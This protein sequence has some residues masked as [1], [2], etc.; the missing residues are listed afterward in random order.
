MWHPATRRSPHLSLPNMRSSICETW[1]A[2][3][4][5]PHQNGMMKH[6]L[7]QSGTR[8]YAC[9]VSCAAHVDPVS[10]SL[11]SPFLS[12]FTPLV[13]EDG[14]NRCT[15][16]WWLRYI[17]RAEALST[18][19]VYC[20]PVLNNSQCKMTEG[21]LESAWATMPSVSSFQLANWFFCRLTF[22]GESL[23]FSCHQTDFNIRRDWHRQ[24]RNV[25][26]E[27]WFHRPSWFTHD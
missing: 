19:R 11:F 22:C 17:R 2:S 6:L 1:L 27:W 12:V 5:Q 13:T 25:V 14:A 20:V 4:Q 8:K 15:P 3:L 10:S 9:K 24:M 26:F 7:P 21:N 18:S 23:I 16:T